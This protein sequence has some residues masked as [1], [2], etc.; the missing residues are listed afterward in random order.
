MYLEEAKYQEKQ[1]I[2]DGLEVIESVLKMF[3]RILDIHS[4]SMGLGSKL[5]A[6]LGTS[7]VAM[8]FGELN[9]SF[10]ISSLRTQSRGVSGT[11]F[12][13]SPY[14][15]FQHFQR[16]LMHPSGWVFVSGPA[17]LDALCFD[18][19]ALDALRLTRCA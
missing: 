14:G 15:K 5:I 19:A 10:V 6:T 9:A 12:N 2:F 16:F 11:I 4:T 1:N 3:V 13:M 18:A 17:T 7:E 8:I